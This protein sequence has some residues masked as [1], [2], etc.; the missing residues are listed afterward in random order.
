MDAQLAHS[1]VERGVLELVRVSDAVS[2][3]VAEALLVC[4]ALG[5]CVPVD[6]VDAVTVAGAGVAERDC[7]VHTCTL[8]TSR[9]ESNELSRTLRTLNCSV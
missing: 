9:A 3:A 4:E 7:S 2:E 5:V 1:V 6:D 8:S